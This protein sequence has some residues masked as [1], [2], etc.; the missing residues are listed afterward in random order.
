MHFGR[1]EEAPRSQVAVSAMAL[2][3]EA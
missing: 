3:D 1:I 2:K